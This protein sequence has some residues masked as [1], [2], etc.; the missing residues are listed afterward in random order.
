MPKLQILR[1]LKEQ[2]LSFPNI[3]RCLSLPQGTIKGWEEK[4]SI[5]KDGQALMKIVTMFP[6]MLE[7]A[8]NDFRDP[9]RKLLDQVDITIKLKSR[10]IGFNSA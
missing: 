7:V 6:W 10:K 3:E 1:D 9:N 5:P 2:G 8:D 4:G